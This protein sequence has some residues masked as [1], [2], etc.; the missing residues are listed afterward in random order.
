M[1]SRGLLPCSFS[2]AVFSFA[3][4]QSIALRPRTVTSRLEWARWKRKRS[5]KEQR[6]WGSC[7]RKKKKAWEKCGS[8][9]WQLRWDLV[10]RVS[11]VVSLTAL[12]ASLWVCFSASLYVW[13]SGDAP[14]KGEQQWGVIHDFIAQAASNAPSFSP[15]AT[16]CFFPMIPLFFSYLSYS[17][18]YTFASPPSP[19]HLQLSLF[20]FAFFFMFFKVQ[21]LS[22]FYYVSHLS[23]F[24]FFLSSFLFRLFCSESIPV[25]HTLPFSLILQIDPVAPIKP[26]SWNNFTY[27]TWMCCCHQEMRFL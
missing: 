4:C 5:Q 18:L 17:F 10:F 22:F 21:I 12:P 23:V 13:V 25:F 19:R 20:L 6:R 16:L 27:F 8:L 9:G 1:V 7:A 2:A 15:P 24:F 11:M 14:S 26:L 3:L